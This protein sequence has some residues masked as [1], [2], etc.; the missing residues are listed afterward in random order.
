MVQFI[1]NYLFSPSASVSQPT[2]VEEEEEEDED[3]E[4]GNDEESEESED[5]TGE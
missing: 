2:G 1:T 4:D 5:G 3:D